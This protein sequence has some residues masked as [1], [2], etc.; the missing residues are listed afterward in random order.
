MLEVLEVLKIQDAIE[1]HPAT[2][3]IGCPTSSKVTRPDTIL[4]ENPQATGKLPDKVLSSNRGM[5]GV[6]S[7]PTL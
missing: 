7:G 6:H 3:A 1:V 5:R 2:L 4:A